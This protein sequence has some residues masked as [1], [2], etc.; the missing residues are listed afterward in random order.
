MDL[1]QETFEEEEASVIL[2]TPINSL[3]SKD[4]LIWHGT[5]NGYFSVKSAY[6]MEKAKEM[7]GRGQASTSKTFKENMTKALNDSELQEF[8]MVA[9]QLWLRR[10]S[11][12]FKNKFLPP[13]CLLREASLRL[14]LLKEDEDKIQT[15]KEGQQTKNSAEKWQSPPAN[16]FKVNWDEAIDKTKCMIGIGIVLRDEKGQIIST[17]RHKKMQLPDP[18]LTES[19]GAL[20]AIQFTKDLGLTQ[21][22]LEG[23]SLQVTKA[24]QEE[25]EAWSSSSMFI[26]E[27][28]IWLKTFSMWHVSHVRRNGNNIAHL[29]AKGS[30]SIFDV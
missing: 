27:T 17:M 29:L 28:R 6:H 3:N 4:K 22:E 5:K 12:I 23:D 25:N 14:Q 16:W 8:V 10:N 1:V 11:I 13:N 2:Q 19:Y 15:Q 20:V 7:E 9:R 21:I 26:V 24:L 18:L 30:L